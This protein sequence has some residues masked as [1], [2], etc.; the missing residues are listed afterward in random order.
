[1]AELDGVALAT[2]PDLIMVLE[3]QTRVIPITTEGLRYGQRVTVLV[4]PC[5]PRWH[6]RTWH[7]SD[8]RYFGYDIDPVTT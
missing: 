6:T 1:M 2:T 8:P 5:D 4:A 3:Q 7:S